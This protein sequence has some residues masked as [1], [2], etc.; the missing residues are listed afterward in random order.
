MTKYLIG[1]IIIMG[2]IIAMM[3]QSMTDAQEKKQVAESNI[4]ALTSKIDVYKIEN[5]QL[6]YKIRGLELS[7]RTFKQLF[8]SLYMEA[9]DLKLRLKNAQSVTK[10]VTKIE[11]KNKD[12]IVYIPIVDSQSNSKKYIIAEPFLKAE[13]LTTKDSIILPGNF[14]IIDIPNQQ[15]SVPVIE[16]RGW[17]FWRKPKAVVVHI[18]NTN[19]YIQVT[20]GIY[21]DLS[22]K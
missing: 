18:T 10:I 14:K 13:V 21:I 7:E 16:Y 9:S 17:W 4:A 1:L 2:I 20:D 5:N 3:Y 19:P 22:R 8:D 12:S 11:Y 15:L 6:V